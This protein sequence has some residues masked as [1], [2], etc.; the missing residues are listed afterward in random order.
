MWIQCSVSVNSM[1]IQCAFN[2]DSMCCQCGFNMDS[3]L[4][5]C[6]FNV[7]LMWTQSSLIVDLMLIQCDFTVDSTW[8]EHGFNVDSMT[9]LLR[10]HFSRTIPLA[11]N[12]DTSAWKPRSVVLFPISV[13][14]PP[15]RNQ[16]RVQ[17]VSRRTCYPL[18]YIS[19]Q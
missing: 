13:P 10:L 4:I 18:W 3:V 17:L 12:L 15:M 16:T 11:P 19:I 5:H 2:V 8:I 6:G 9:S 1:L 14:D 7:E